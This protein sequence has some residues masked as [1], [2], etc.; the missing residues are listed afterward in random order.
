MP[1]EIPAVCV[2]RCLIV[3]G[4]VRELWDVATHGIVETDLPFLDQRKDRDG[5]ERLALRGDAEQRIDGHRTVRL[6]VAPTGG[7]LV[8]DFAVVQHHGDGPADAAR[9]D[10]L[11]H[12]A[13]EP[14]QSIAR[15]T[16]LSRPG[17]SCS[18][19]SLWREQRRRSSEQQEKDE[20]PGSIH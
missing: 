14:R 15:K 13:V 8:C 18:R 12:E 1:Y 11:L 5:R 2:S 9:I 17:S 7:V 19:A 20:K 10:V 3:I 16:C 6:D 4:G